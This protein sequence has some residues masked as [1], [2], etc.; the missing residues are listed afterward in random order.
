[1]ISVV[2]ARLRRP[3]LAV[4]GAGL[5]AGAAGPATMTLAPAAH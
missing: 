1:M 5:T 3:P 2:S 4:A